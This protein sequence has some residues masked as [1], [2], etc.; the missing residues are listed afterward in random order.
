MSIV[1][2]GDVDVVVD[3]RHQLE[4]ALGRRGVAVE[5][6]Q[7][8]AL[9]DR[10]VVAGELVERQQLAD[11]ELDELEQLLVVHHVGLVEEHDD[12]RHADL[13]GEQDV[14]TRLGH[15]A[16]GGGDHQDRA[17]H[18]RGAGDHVLDVVGVARAVDVGVVPV[19]GLVLDVGGRDRDAALALLG[20]LVDG[21]ERDGLGA[22]GALLGEDLGDG[23]RQGRLAMIDVTD[24]A[25]VHVRLRPVE[26]LFRHR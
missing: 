26:L 6:V 2:L 20:G 25:H 1:A 4:D 9:D 17:V 7:G 16:V 24:G 3:R 15:G 23:G 8:G 21:V 5:G 10:D 13:A 22:T 14:L 18:L 11:L 12:R 19:L